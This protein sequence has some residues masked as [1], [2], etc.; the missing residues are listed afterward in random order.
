MD[1]FYDDDE[2][3]DEYQ[4]EDEDYNFRHS[5]QRYDPS[6]AGAA[7]APLSASSSSSSLSSSREESFRRVPLAPSKA[8]Q[9]S[10]PMSVRPKGSSSTVYEYSLRQAAGRGRG[11]GMP[12]QIAEV[13]PNVSSVRPLG[14]NLSSADSLS[15]P[16]LAAPHLGR[17]IT[18]F[19]THVLHQ[20]PPLSLQNSLPTSVPL[21][22]YQGSMP[23]GLGQAPQS[24]QFEDS[25]D[26]RAQMGGTSSGEASAAVASE[27][28]GGRQSLGEKMKAMQLR[29]QVESTPELENLNLQQAFSRQVMTDESRQQQPQH[30][31]FANR[32]ASGVVSNRSVPAPGLARGRGRGLEHSSQLRSPNSLSTALSLQVQ[33]KSE[34]EKT[35]PVNLGQERLVEAA[36]TGAGAGSK[37]NQKQDYSKMSAEELT[38]AKR[39]LEK[40]MK[41]ISVLET[42]ASEGNVLSSEEDAKL[43]KKPSILTELTKIGQYL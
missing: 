16:S 42:K 26:L 40:K 41:Q 20:N 29:K 15:R 8:A 1:R 13:R 12:A 17:G 19:S 22:S 25:E 14:V 10:A 11:R 34:E 3:E 23:R 39:K 36:E 27:A 9:L 5:R 37:A 28:E 4:K 32:A 24:L 31:T 38:K 7:A 35:T 6:A 30:P 21:P 43:R 33:T 18:R 2:D